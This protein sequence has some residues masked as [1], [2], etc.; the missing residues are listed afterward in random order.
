MRRFTRWVALRSNSVQAEFLRATVTPIAFLCVAFLWSQD[1]A[2]QVEERETSED[3]SEDSAPLAADEV[4]LSDP[5]PDQGI[6]QRVESG[7]LRIPGQDTGALKRDSKI[8]RRL[9][10]LKDRVKREVADRRQRLPSGQTKKLSELGLADLTRPKSHKVNDAGAIQ[11]YVV[12]DS[13]TAA[14]QNALRAAGLKI[15]LA[16]PKMNTV[17]GW[18]PYDK[19]DSIGELGFV[20]RVKLPGYAVHRTGSVNTEADSLL[21]ADDLRS[22]SSPGP[23]DGSGVKVGIISDGVDSRASAIASGD[24]PPTI[25]IHPT[26]GGSGDEGTA[27]LEIVHDLAPGADLYFAGPETSAEMVAA[28]DWMANT[29]D[30][31]VICDDL[32]VFDQAIFEDGPVALEA[33][34]AVTTS[35]RIYVSSAGNAAT[36]H[37]QGGYTNSGIRKFGVIT[38]WHDFKV[39][40]G[41]DIG[42]NFT[43]P[44]ADPGPPLVPGRMTVVLQWTDAFGTSSNDYDLVVANT[45]MTS[46]F[47]ASLNVQNGNDDP[48]EIVQLANSGPTAVNTVVMVYAASAFS[49]TLELYVYGA[50]PGDDD[51]TAADSIW[52][53]PAVTEV[54]SCAAISALDP[55]LNDIESFSSLGPSTITVPTTQVRATPTITSL[56]GVSVTGAGGFPSRFYGTSASAPHVAAICALILERHP[57]VTSAEVR[58][59]LAGRSLDRGTPGFDNTFGNGLIDAQLLASGLSDSSEVWVDFAY[60]STEVGTEAEPF[61]TLAE[62]LADVESAGIIFTK[63]GTSTEMADINQLVDIVPVGG[64]VSILP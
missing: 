18:A 13:V 53:H 35:G 57:G 52:G 43:I 1:A 60:L 17:Q 45:A 30:C 46:A 15:D 39:G 26:I 56:D 64:E 50:T 36:R 47:G 29:V 63:A 20:S 40:P 44:A 8:D 49:R 59:V 3:Q 2:A 54:I 41:S 27:L 10:L 22:M 51:L 5:S 37:Y 9:V 16:V 12:V 4:E 25:T 7:K 48:Y 14:V 24:L 62:G 23:Y 32:A 55:G 11:V 28:I 21:N 19:I 38:T 31:D 42:L 58:A 34:D 61:N 6:D 33:R